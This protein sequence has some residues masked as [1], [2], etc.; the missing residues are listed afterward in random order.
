GVITI[1][2]DAVT[3]DDLMVAALD[4][5]AD[6]IQKDDGTFRVLTSPTA[7]E[8]VKAALEKAGIAIESAEVTMEPTTTVHLEGKQAEQVLKLMDVL[9]E[10]DDVQ[11]V[12]SNFDIDEKTMEAMNA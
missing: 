4:A 11:N 10:H 2:A 6:D 5:G 7:L 1:S 9:E 12:F 8:T 3:E